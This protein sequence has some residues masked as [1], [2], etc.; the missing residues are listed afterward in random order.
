MP[1][2]P[3][4]HQ[5]CGPTPVVQTPRRGLLAAAVTLFGLWCAALAILTVTT[6]NPPVL[7]GRQL[8]QARAL[9]TVVVEDVAAGSCRVRERWS[10][11]EIPD[12]LRVTNL[13]ATGA[14]AG[15]EYILPLRADPVAEDGAFRVVELPLRGLPPLIYPR[16]P[17]VERQLR[18][19]QRPQP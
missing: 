19:W 1:S 3:A 15:R 12:R 2:P 18:A 9:V 8:A 17:E 13:S 11:G 6:A 14:V 7:N 10:P 16:T 4:A 5:P